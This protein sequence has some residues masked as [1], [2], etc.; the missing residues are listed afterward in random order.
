MDEIE[1]ARMTHKGT[2]FHMQYLSR[3]KRQSRGAFP[4]YISVWA[5][6]VSSTQKDNRDIRYWIIPQYQSNMP[7]NIA[8]ILLWWVS[9][10][11]VPIINK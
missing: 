11:G 8:D 10:F 1:V 7:M 2:S 4:W 3:L 5:G 6:G 9:F